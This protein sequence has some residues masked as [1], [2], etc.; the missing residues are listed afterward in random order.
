MN[1]APLRGA[2]PN[3]ETILFFT[4]EDAEERQRLLWK[5]YLTIADLPLRHP[6]A[7]RSMLLILLLKRPS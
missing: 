1:S 4:A 7:L 2:A 3:P 6:S 5:E